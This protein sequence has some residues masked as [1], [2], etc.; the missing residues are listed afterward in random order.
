MN[1]GRENL[2]DILARYQVRVRE[3]D[4]I[5]ARRGGPVR[6]LEPAFPLDQTPSRREIDVLE[7]VAEGLSN[8]EIAGRLVLSEDTVKTHVRSLLVKLGA[9]NRAHAV[10]LGFEQSLISFG[11]SAEAA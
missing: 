9:R 5:A 6:R 8:K 2:Q 11:A 4:E 7:L 1:R 3:F 10:T